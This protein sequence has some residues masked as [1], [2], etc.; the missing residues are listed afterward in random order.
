VAA[1]P[2]VHATIIAEDSPKGEGVSPIPR[3]DI[4]NYA[5]NEDSIGY[6]YLRKANQ[7]SENPE[8]AQKYWLKG[9]QLK[10]KA[11]TLFEELSLTNLGTLENCAETA[12]YIS[13]KYLKASKRLREANSEQADEYW[14]EGMEWKEKTYTSYKE[15]S[16]TDPSKEQDC[17]LT[18]AQLGEEFSE[19]GIDYKAIEWY[20]KALEHNPDNESVKNKYEALCI[21]MASEDLERER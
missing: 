20:E 2:V 21:K 14:L 6:A 5:L 18:A 4:K 11:Y 12:A 3:N 13:K 1:F 10:K 8:Q 17:A 16:H 9:M 19:K 15:L 7:S